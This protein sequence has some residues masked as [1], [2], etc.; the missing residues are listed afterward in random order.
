MSNSVN[1]VMPLPCRSLAQRR[2]PE[3]TSNAG[4]VREAAS[5]RRW[6]LT[7]EPVPNFCILRTS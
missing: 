6:S 5:R 1:Q 7:S 2:T 3:I 4:D